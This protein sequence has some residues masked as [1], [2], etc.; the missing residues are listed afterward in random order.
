MTERRGPMRSLLDREVRTR[1]GDAFGHQ[2]FAVALESLVEA[3]AHEPPFSIGL[4]GQWGTGKS[5]IRSLYVS[6]LEDAASKD[7]K[8]LTRSE[9]IFPVSFNAWRFGGE[10]LKRALLRQVF[11]ELGGDDSVLKDRVFRQ[12]QRAVPEPKTSEDVSRELREKWLWPV[13]QVIAVF[14]VALISLLLL[15]PL[16]TNVLV[17]TVLVGGFTAAAGF[18]IK[19]L[20]DPRRFVISTTSNFTR[21]E[22]PSSSAEE[23]EDLLKEQLGRFKSGEAGIVQ[24]KTCERIVVFVDDLDRL[25]AEEMVNGLDAI[26]TFMDIPQAVPDGPGMVF[27]ISCDEERV[28]DAL[29]DRRRQQ[30]NPE[31]PGAI[32][33]R[34]DARRFLDRI[35]Q[36]RLEIP[37]LPKR[38]MR[39]YAK[40]RLVADLSDVAED[41]RG[42]GVDLD[43]LVDRMMHPGVG[44]PRDAVHILNAFAQTWWL[45]RRRERE[46]G[47]ERP[48]GL[49]EG[50]VTDHPLTLATLC[51]LQ[52][53]FPDFYGKLRRRADLLDGF[54]EVFVRGGSPDR[55]PDDV[56][57]LL[58]EY[59]EDG[60]NAVSP[61]H[62]PLRRYV[63]S[64]QG[65]RRPK[66]LQPLLL[67]SQDPLSRRLG[68]RTEAVVDAFVSGDSSGVLEALG[69]ERDRRTF[70]NEDIALLEGVVEDTE[71]ETE[72]RRINGGMVL[73]ELAEMF[74]EDR[75]ERLLSPLA[76]RV[77]AF[78]KLRSRVGVDGIGGL[79]GRVG[80][81][82][83]RDLAG[84][85]AG[86]LLKSDGEISLRTR[87]GET[88]S[89]DE[90]IG[91][92]EKGLLIALGV[93]RRDELRPGNDES[94]LAWL[95]VRH[96]A[97]D[98]REYT[99][100][101]AKLE[102]WLDEHEDHLLRALAGRYTSMVADELRA[103]SAEN[104]DM[105][106]VRRRSLEI[107]GRLRGQGQESRE[108]V[109]DW[110]GEFVAGR[111]KETCAGAWEF[112]GANQAEA[113]AA[114]VNG[115]VRRLGERLFRSWEDEDWAID[116]EAGG[117]ALLDIA[118][119]RQN[120][121]RGDAADALTNLAQA[122]C[123]SEASSVLNDLAVGYLGVLRV[124]DLLHSYET[125]ENWAGR[126]LDDL[127]DPGVDWLGEHFVDGMDDDRR[128]VVIAHLDQV[129]QRVDLTEE[130][131][132]RYRR[133]M[134]S[135]SENGTNTAEI[136][137]HLANLM[138][139]IT[140]QHQNPNG[141]L[142]RVF[143]VAAALVE[144][145]P[146]EQATQMLNG[147]FPNAQ[148]Q[149]E[150]FGWLHGQMV[151]HW[152]DPN[153][154]DYATD[155]L[156]AQATTFVGT[157]P[158][159]DGAKHVLASL[160]SMV[161]K[162]VVG[163]SRSVEVLNAACALWPYHAQASLR[164]IMGFRTAP[165]S[166]Q[167]AGLAEGVDLDEAEAAGF[168]REAWSHV[169]GAMEQEDRLLASEEL[170]ALSPRNPEDD[171]DFALR[172]WVEA[173]QDPAALL[174][175]LLLKG[176]LPD[177]H[178]K[179]LWLQVDR[180]A[181]ELGP[182]YF[183][184]IL[185]RL[186]ALPDL[187]QT[188]QEVLRS[189][190]SISALFPE[191]QDKNELGR[192]LLNALVD[193]PSR[194][195]KNRLARWMKDLGAG[196]ALARLGKENTP[197]A[198]DLD[199]L[200]SSFPQ[201]RYLKKYRD[202]VGDE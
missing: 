53:D 187:P 163:D 104:L 44:N 64:L 138:A 197:S 65:L 150:L 42:R 129:H 137:Q 93:R 155:E 139:Q 114:Q 176:D 186:L 115:F 194:E 16:I 23:Y 72:E 83:R 24:G 63:S 178:S 85:I 39:S 164:T 169:A 175:E 96:V 166:E 201:S 202:S 149:P 156:F 145:G 28:A 73:A 116:D 140:Q 95:Q 35:F 11:I 26:R 136:G 71:G 94:L 51:V 160:Q 74:P 57:V 37:P 79:V 54:E 131:G 10:D 52:V 143:P 25:S 134:E 43:V 196:D 192:S 106:K 162:G 30:A 130:E 191:I 61:A 153:E 91:M 108:I 113:T 27:V 103:D 141:Y 14:A 60:T 3:E 174:R 165:S 15:L 107:F 56:R 199:V 101:F 9:K 109:W 183:V 70:S 81:D 198:E 48:G 17:Q 168:L 110:L 112:A 180:R 148:S 36:F 105:A 49:Q 142:Y 7:T 195:I 181:D 84:R 120:E 125:I 102:E 66:S 18:A 123:T 144:H 119:A 59:G 167:V 88:P 68:D 172:L 124:V 86:D 82:D 117:R 122:W 179:R 38:D 2:D 45:A 98:D 77:A 189:Q 161:K 22:P 152:P 171:P 97:S 188:Y 184:D 47:T 67:L 185:P 193:S 31:A 177:E 173:Q 29:A 8:G 100:P 90:A 1:D 41:L 21:L 46:A 50:A 40:K 159:P 55:Q 154:L 32:F 12:I 135:L 146:A 157:Y 5:T 132:R 80:R 190:E 170:L 76:R 6:S 20:L 118:Q 200:E 92:A 147:L 19:W 87:N 158:Q 33:S 34:D 127:G 151:G 62:R 126:I 4:L 75:A 89:L 69:R 111:P 133:F 78:P 99:F 182:S 13:L 121:L 128:A 58:G